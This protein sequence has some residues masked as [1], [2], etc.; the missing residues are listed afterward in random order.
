MIFS[1]HLQDYYL[2]WSNFP[3]MFNY[4]TFTLCSVRNPRDKS[5]VWALSFSLAATK[6]IDFSF[7]SSRYL[8]VSVPQVYP[9]IAIYSLYNTWGFPCEFPHSEIFGSLVMCTYPKLIAA[10]HVLHRLLMPRHSPCA[11]CSLTSA[12]LL[13][14]ITASTS[15][16]VRSRTLKYCSLTKYFVSL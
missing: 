8:D 14:P 3:V 2:L 6:K 7:S 9:Y 11:L 15:Y 5:L 10:Y 13:P 12:C 4:D 16:F 1:F